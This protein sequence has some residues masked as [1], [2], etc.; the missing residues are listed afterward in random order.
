M[1]WRFQIGSNS[2]FANRKARML[3]TDS[4]PREWSI[5]RI[6]D[7]SKTLWYAWFRSRAEARSVPNGFSAMTRDPSARPMAPIIATTDLAAAGGTA[8]WNSRCGGPPISFSAFSTATASDPV[9]DGPAAPNE[10]RCLKSSQAGPVGFCVPN[11]S[12]ASRAW[13]R[14]CS[15]V[16]AE[17]FG[18]EP[19]IRYSSGSSPAAARWNRPGSSL[20]LARSPVA[21]NSTMTWLSTCGPRLRATAADCD[22]ACAE[23]VSVLISVRL[24]LLVAA[25]PGAHSGQHLEAEHAVAA[26]VEPLVQG[27]RDG[28]GR[29]AG[30]DGRLDGPPALAGVGHPAVEVAEVG[31]PG[32]R[33]GGQVDQPGADHRAAPPDL[34][35][36][37]HVDRVLVGLGLAQRGRLGVDLVLVLARVGVLDDVKALGDRGHHAVLDAVV[38][39]LD[40]VPGAVGPAVQV[41]LGGGAAVLRPAG[42]RHRVA[43]A[44]GDGPEDRVEPLDRL[45]LAPDHQAEPALQPPDAAAGAAVDVVDAVGPQLLGPGDVV[46]VV[47]VAAV[48]HHV[49]GVQ[50]RPQLVQGLL[51]DAGGHHDPQ[52]PGALQLGHEVA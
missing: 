16:S 20:R 23:C 29:H 5:R 2:P 45:G 38:D 8:R 7:S 42:R 11:W 41:P 48:D 15:S 3:S 17:F 47:G 49:V 21:P 37:A 25:E 10:S 33:V 19:M 28:R 1:C 36:L 44:G 32:E 30:V 12:I 43:L 51:H 40:E 4:L 27:G 50:Q 26:G 34:G 24:L 6:C 35:H 9:S 31:R 39:H 14:N 22:L 18:A 52:G 46:P 13:S